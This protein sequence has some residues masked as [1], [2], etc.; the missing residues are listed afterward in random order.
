VLR[1]QH[2]AAAPGQG[3]ECIDHRVFRAPRLACAAPE[4]GDALKKFVEKDE[5]TSLADAYNSALKATEDAAIA[6]L[7]V[8]EATAAD[9]AAEDREPDA[10]DVE[11]ER[12]VDS[13]SAAGKRLQAVAEA[14]FADGDAR[15]RSAARDSARRE[16]GADGEAGPASRDEAGAH[17]VLCVGSHFR[18]PAPRGGRCS[19][20]AAGG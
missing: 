10:E 20:H 3:L 16:E 11:F 2:S 1:R 4:L 6:D 15:L 13:V 8:P 12:I 9:G 17:H 18:R 19:S 7:T 14:K 5:K